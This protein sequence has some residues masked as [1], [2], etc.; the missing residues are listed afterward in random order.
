MP[1]HPVLTKTQVEI[2]IEGFSKLYFSLVQSDAPNVGR[3]ELGGT[4]TEK[5]K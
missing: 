3:I 2:S 1:P 5:L 4:P